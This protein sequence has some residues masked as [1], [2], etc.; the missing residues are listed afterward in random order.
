MRTITTYR[1]INGWW[2]RIDKPGSRMDRGPY[3]FEWMARAAF[4]FQRFWW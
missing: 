3:Y 2:A 4:P 1:G